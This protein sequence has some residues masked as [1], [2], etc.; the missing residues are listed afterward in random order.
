MANE[1][2]LWPH[3]SKRDELNDVV[4]LNLMTPS[5]SIAP[6]YVQLL[7]IKRSQDHIHIS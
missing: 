5:S 2:I 7:Q 4:R 6:H 1:Q 3:K